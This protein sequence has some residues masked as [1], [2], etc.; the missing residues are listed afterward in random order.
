MGCHARDMADI[1]SASG[2]S[3]KLVSPQVIAGPMFSNRALGDQHE[4]SVSEQAPEPGYS[5]VVS[6]YEDH[7]ISAGMAGHNRNNSKLD[8]RASE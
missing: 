1:Y 5:K 2:N 3:R 6:D 4:D 7:K 8:S